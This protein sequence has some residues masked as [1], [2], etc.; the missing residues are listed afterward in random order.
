MKT[1]QSQMQ[2]ASSCYPQTCFNYAKN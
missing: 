1:E 2:C